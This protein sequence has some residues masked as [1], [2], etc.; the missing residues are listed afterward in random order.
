MMRDDE[1]TTWG[2]EWASLYYPVIKAKR[3]VLIRMG[4][5]HLFFG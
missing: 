2:S 5:D 1:A 4:T 3:H